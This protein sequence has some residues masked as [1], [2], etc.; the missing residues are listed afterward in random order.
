MTVQ[1]MYPK[2]PV[3]KITEDQRSQFARDGYFVLEGALSKE[4]VGRLVREVDRLYAREV[5]QSSDPNPTRRLDLKK[6]VEEGDAFVDLIDHP[7]T[8]DI[9]LDLLG[10]YIQLG[11]SIITVHPPNPD[12]RGFLHVDGGPAMQRIRVSESSWPLQVKIIYFLTDVPAPDMGNILVVPG[13]HLRPYPEGE[14][15]KLG[16]LP[17][18]T[19]GAVQTCAR[20]GD[21]IFFTHSLWHGGAQNASTVSRKNVQYGYNQIFFRL[22]SNEQTPVDLLE[23]CTPRQ[24]RLLGDFGPGAE[25]N[26]HFYPPEDHVRLM[27]PER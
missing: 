20:A 21:A 12:Y 17:A 15:N 1:L 24:R 10:P 26:L 25:P 5:M 11:I 22:Y 27:I 14:G 16:E 19:P 2:P 4:E 3:R 23:R 8:F 13:S 7:A 18:D 9:L 6:V